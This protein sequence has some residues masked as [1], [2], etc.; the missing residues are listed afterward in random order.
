M[1]TLSSVPVETISGLI[2]RVT[3]YSDE[4]GFAVLRVKTKGQQEL[5]TVIG[6]VAAAN[7]GEWVTAE[8]R[9]I[10]DREHGLQFKA[11]LLQ[12]V[13]PTSQEG[14]E[15]YLGSGMIKGIGPVYASKLVKK[16]GEKIFDI[17]DNESARLQ[18][19]DGIGPGRRK[20]IKA[21]WGEQ[22]FIRQIMV[23]LHSNGVGT[24][25]AVRIY[26]TYGE[27]A[28][29]RVRENPY[30]LAHDIPGIGFLTADQIGLKLGISRESILRA[31]AALEH[32]LAEA[33]SDGHCALP[34]S[35]LIEQATTL[36]KV[37]ETLVAEALRQMLEKRFL[38]EELIGDEHLIFLPNLKKAE[39][40]IATLLTGL[41]CTRPNYPRINAPTAIDW[42]EKRSGRE[43]APSQRAAL[44]QALISSAL[45]IT[46]GPG[47]GK[48]TL[49]H[50]LLQ[51]LT[52][53]KLR[54]LLCAPTGRAAKRLA[55]S[56]G[57][58]AQTI[59]RLLEFDSKQGRFTRNENRPLDAD[60][61]VVDETSM[62]DVPL[63]HSLLRAH[64]PKAALIL[65][66]DVDQLPSVGPGSVLA[67]IIAS[68]RIPVV[69]L[70]EVFRQAAASRIITNAH[71]INQG[72]MPEMS[73]RNQESDFY[74]I[75]RETPE[76]ITETLLAMV[77]TRIPG[78]FQVDPIRDIQVLTPM[79]RGSL[80]V[81]ELN[82]ALQERLNPVRSGE[83]MVQRFGWQF[84]SGDKVI[85][86]VNNYDKE[87]F[88][89]D[90]GIILSIDPSE[91]E[92]RIHFENREI[93]YDFGE[94]DEINLAYAITVH[95][96]QGSEFPVVVMPVA[97]QQ[98]LLLQRNLIYTG[99]T[100]GRRLVV[101]IGQ[102][103]ALSIA[104][105][106]QQSGRRY[107][108]LLTRLKAID[109]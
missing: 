41:L 49:L 15:K 32:V 85:Q 10:R 12:S 1:T 53:K 55:Q 46:G 13:P 31:T 104:V 90:I 103:K 9:W 60:L 79:N 108:G 109:S 29:D 38:V 50:S 4:T 75:E 2:E 102:P 40:G 37:N 7:P 28:I 97:T 19:V 106:T 54:P 82:L 92:I 36:L 81:R 16:F 24:A 65:V 35:I 88:N 45:V 62:V 101:L 76:E 26:K 27:S 89:G 69:R 64:P 30:V 70:T 67:D 5:V 100:R 58:P 59:H 68:E 39:E 83:E 34:R 86:T 47:V 66:G 52:A 56:T 91:R 23:F 11:E 44:T 98:Y 84:R 33:L 105:R 80:G 87:V 14:I 78:K 43:L 22:K 57:L 42:C 107:S 72:A 3:F 93:V 8:G 21:A 71:R 95:K 77:Q 74:F 17:I 25:R 51:I 48:T 63:M 99:V 6:N 94:L 96:A 18:E 20:K 73:E 61:V